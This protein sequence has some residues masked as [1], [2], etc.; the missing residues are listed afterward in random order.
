MQPGIE[1]DLF[2]GFASISVDRKLYTE[3]AIFKAAYWFTDKFYV[4]LASAG[5]DKVLI[6]LRGKAELSDQELTAACSEF[7]NSLVDHRVRQ[8]VLE[9]TKTIREALVVKAFDE[10]I[11]RHFQDD[12]DTGALT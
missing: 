4:Y 5:E 1:T 9:E 6:E 3:A 7:C 12:G 8:V 2:G 11:P 10:G